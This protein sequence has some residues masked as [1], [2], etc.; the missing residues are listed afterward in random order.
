[1]KTIT[2]KQARTGTVE[3]NSRGASAPKEQ[4]VQFKSLEVPSFTT[5]PVNGQVDVGATITITIGDVTGNITPS[6]LVDDQPADGYAEILADDDSNQYTVK[7]SAL[8]PGTI[9]LHIEGDSIDP[10]DHEFTILE[11]DVVALDM[12]PANGNVLDDEEILVSVTGTTKNITMRASDPKITVTPTNVGD[13]TN[14]EFTIS[15]SGPV[16]GNLIVEG[17][18]VVTLEQEVTFREFDVITVTPDPVPATDI[19]EEIVLTVSGTER[20]INATCSNPDITP[21]VSDKT[22]T[23]S[24]T[25][26]GTG[27]IVITGDHVQEK[28]VEVVFT[29]PDRISLDVEPRNGETY[30][31]SNIIVTV[32]G[33]TKPIKFRS[34]NGDVK[35]STTGI[36][37]VYSIRSDVPV[38]SAEVEFYGDDIKP[39]KTTVTFLERAQAPQ[40]TV[41]TSKIEL[42]EDQLPHTFSVSNLQGTLVATSSTSYVVVSVSGSDVTIESVKPGKMPVSGRITLHV[43]GQ[44]DQYVPFTITAL[45]ELPTMDCDGLVIESTPGVETYFNVPMKDD[46]DVVTVT[47]SSREVT[48]D[49]RDLNRVYVKSDVL[50][51]YIINVTHS[52]H[53][54]ATVT[55]KVKEEPVIIEPDEDS[56][57]YYDL[58]KCPD[59]DVPVKNDNVIDSVFTSSLLAND[60]ERLSYIIKNGDYVSKDI[61]NVFCTYN[62]DFGDPYYL[63][64][65]EEIGSFNRRV[66]QKIYYVLN[67]EDYYTF[68][69]YFRLILKTFKVYKDTA[70]KDI[71][72]MRGEDGWKGSPSEL[73]QYK[74]I[75]SFICKYIDMNGQNVTVTL[76]TMPFSDRVTDKLVQFCSE[77]IIP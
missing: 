68:K 23:I 38:A 76:S 10:T 54:P 77:N 52:E 50:G 60:R 46:D 47:C 55:F 42:R 18:G 37:Y 19:S 14:K 57:N 59:V 49:E 11:P 7:V 25:D 6:L 73:E 34:N 48:I 28:I 67:I 21:V 41:D 72:M 9:K 75:V 36:D 69:E 66:F 74:M 62:K 8:K 53:K 63:P 31:G 51:T 27:E 44:I 15:A 30:V 2:S 17:V 56:N 29:S 5:V 58:G 12:E 26:V 20:T 4:E 39:V 13:P 24:A 70:F 45:P 40:F 64:S 16:V 71:R 22:I 61:L 1:M 43:D 3:V 32:N 65:D 35:V 33:T